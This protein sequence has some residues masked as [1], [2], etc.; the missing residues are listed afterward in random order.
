MTL[1]QRARAAGRTVSE[2]LDELPIPAARV[3]IRRAARRRHLT[4]AAAGLVVLVAVGVGIAAAAHDPDAEAPAV[5]TPEPLPEGWT[6]LDK[7]DA[8]LPSGSS[9]T[10]I[11]ADD[12]SAV[13]AGGVPAG[14]G[15]RAAIW[16]T[17]DGRTWHEADHPEVDG[18]VFAVTL[19]RGVGVAIGNEGGP[20]D[21]GGSDFV[22][23]S[24]DAGHTWVEI[25]S[26]PD[27]FGPEA[28]VMG[29]PFAAQ[30]TW[31]DD[32]WVASGGSST[33]YGAIWVS[34]TGESWEQ[35]LE[36]RR[37]GSVTV[38]EGPEGG[39]IAYTGDAMWGTFDPTDWREPG[40]MD[41]PDDRFPVSIA[42]WGTFAVGQSFQRHDAQQLLRSTDGGFT[43][44]VDEAF[45]GA[46]PDQTLRT[47]LRYGPLDVVTG[48]DETNRPNAWVRM[49]D[50]PW[51]AM[52]A[53]HRGDPGG[54][55]DLV[56]VVDGHAVVLGTAPELDRFYVFVPPRDEPSASVP[57]GAPGSLQWLQVSGQIP[58]FDQAKATVGFARFGDVAPFLPTDLRQNALLLDPAAFGEVAIDDDEVAIG[59][60]RGERGD[61]DTGGRGGPAIP[62]LPTDAGLSQNTVLLVEAVGGGAQ[63]R[64]IIDASTIEGLDAVLAPA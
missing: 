41:L 8:G 23:R 49:S 52:P 59:I 44:E 40:T 47:A 6:A 17:D 7:V 10:A 16:W 53:D 19:Y 63:S 20:D 34:R 56:A 54:I 36:T 13:L 37:G 1:D 21:P 38:G 42:G 39:P 26:G 55:L 27:V 45:D 61:F 31:T 43:W 32:W 51:Q 9:L 57:A 64:S 35:V 60:Y 5:T 22:W 2:Q 46:F 30:V 18:E 11:D 58:D 50:G 48:A 4:A 25:A 62:G 33:G 28:P 12:P 29:R 3:P 24:E 14:E 15:W